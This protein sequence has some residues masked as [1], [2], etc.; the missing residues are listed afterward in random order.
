MI[1]GMER[2]GFDLTH[3]Y[4]LTEVYG[5]A[6]VCAKHDEWDDA[7]LARARRAQRPPGRALPA[8]RRA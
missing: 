5:P 4:G 8:A 1:E 2:I 7:R 6:A 3:V